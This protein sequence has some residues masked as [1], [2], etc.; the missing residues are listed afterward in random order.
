MNPIKAFP[1]S[2]ASRRRFALRWSRRADRPKS[3]KDSVAA[4]HR[5]FPLNEPLLR[6]LAVVGQH[7]PPIVPHVR[8]SPAWACP[9][10]GGY[11]GREGQTD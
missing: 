9:L 11:A 2:R 4:W 6:A 7:R 5:R 8:G 3:V 10:P 1:L